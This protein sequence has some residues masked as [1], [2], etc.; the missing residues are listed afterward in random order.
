MHRTAKVLLLAG[1]CLAGTARARP[2]D[3]ILKTK[4]LRIATRN[5]VGITIKHEDGR[6]K[7]FHYCLAEEFARTLDLKIEIHWQPFGFQ[8][9]FFHDGKFPP[10]VIANPNVIYRPDVFKDSDIAVDGFSALPWRR[11]IAD[12]APMVLARQVVIYNKAKIAKVTRAED[13]DGKTVMVKAATVQHELVNQL[14]KSVN[15]HVKFI[16]QSPSETEG[17]DLKPLKDG[18]ADFMVYPAL[19]SI[20][21]VK[22]DANLGFGFPLGE[23]ESSD[24]MIEKGN[25]SLLNELMAF[26]S[27]AEKSGVYDR[28]FIQEYGFRYNQYLRSVDVVRGD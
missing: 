22:A 20:T 12:F 7:G 26:I 27:K 8:H 21:D 24:W 23:A 10:D 16:E 14:K 17:D 1:L 2:L 3:E 9:Y 18:L 13:L 6:H 28:C 5:R 19:Y 4:V 15:I 25:H 11:K